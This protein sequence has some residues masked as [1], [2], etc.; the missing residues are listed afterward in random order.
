MSRVKE[1]RFAKRGK[2]NSALTT[3]FLSSSRTAEIAAEKPDQA[4]DILMD[5]LTSGTPEQKAKAKEISLSP[6]FIMA[7]TGLNTARNS[8]VGA[9]IEQAKSL[10]PSLQAA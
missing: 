2:P 7:V 6:S 10:T 4:V 1:S 5:A 8:R 3:Y 9:L